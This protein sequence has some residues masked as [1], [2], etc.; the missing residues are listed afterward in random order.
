MTDEFL[1]VWKKVLAGCNTTYLVKYLRV[2]STS[3]LPRRAEA[4][5]A[6]LPRGASH[7]TIAVAA[8]HIDVY[9]T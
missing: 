7:A 9:V 6:A 5:P 1:F 8:K 4:S 2:G 3:T